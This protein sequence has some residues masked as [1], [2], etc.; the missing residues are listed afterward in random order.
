MNRREEIELSHKLRE[1][2]LTSKRT[3]TQLREKKVEAEKIK[4][5]I[6][7]KRIILDT[8]NEHIRKIKR[9]ERKSESC[10]ERTGAG[11]KR[12]RDYYRLYHRGNKWIK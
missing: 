1:L 8:V 11:Q 2:T 4:R 9:K 5:D 10:S 7:E 3:A 12:C 6:I